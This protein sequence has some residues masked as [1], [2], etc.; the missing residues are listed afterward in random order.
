MDPQRPGGLP[1]QAAEPSAARTAASSTHAASSPLVEAASSPGEPA[2]PP[3]EPSAPPADPVPPH[4]ILVLAPVKGSTVEGQLT[5][6]QLADKT[7]ILGV[8]TGLANNAT[9]MLAKR[10]RCLGQ[11]PDD[12][13]RT[14]NPV[15]YG[16][17]LESDRNGVARVLDD[18][19][20]LRLDGPLSMLGA[21][22]VVS[23]TSGGKVLACG[24]VRER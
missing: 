21:Y 5:L 23:R 12:D 24:R 17:A 22:F 8:V 4:A 15:I 19:V 9:Y 10:D 16:V 14:S 6:V 3:D 7:K 11:P 20:A 13:S 1:D 2:S 18:S